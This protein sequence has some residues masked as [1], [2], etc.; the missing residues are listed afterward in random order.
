MSALI[1]HGPADSQG[2]RLSRVLPFVRRHLG[3]DAVVVT[4][5]C[6]GR[7]VCRAFDGDAG[8]FGI[9][10]D[11]AA[12]AE[13]DHPTP[14]AACSASV[15]IALADGR[16]YGTLRCLSAR[17]VVLDDHDATFLSL[18]AEMLA[19][20]LERATTAQRRLADLQQ[21]LMPGAITMA[22]QPIITLATGRCAGV[23]ALARFR[24]VGAT[25]DVVFGQALEAGLAA[26]LELAAV[27]S[28]LAQRPRL[29][30]G[31]YLSVNVGPTAIL[32]PGFGAAIRSSG[33]L[34]GLVL[35]ITEHASVDEYAAL[36]RVLGPLR[37]EGLRLAVDDVGAGYASLRHVLRMRPD[38]IKIDRSLIDGIAGDVAQ[39]S[40]VTSI[41]LL[42]LDMAAEIVA[43]G[44]ER[45][46]D[47]LALA[48]LG[49]DMVQGYLFAAPTVE[50][51]HWD[52]WATRRF[53]PTPDA[54]APMDRQR[55]RTGHP[56]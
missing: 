43:E 27:R 2:N 49:V 31:L 20:Q 19:E 26:E 16:L 41:V 54:G 3:V 18:F 55:D 46:A 23:E 7:D 15:P 45:R 8:A 34:P 17:G 35:E 22:M 38:I 11:G 24:S 56:R 25:P 1:D 5:H 37:D 40:I 33:P 50:R 12:P 53:L 9:V 13:P 42:S 28:A 48:D 39:R 14:G 21:A 36:R 32:A 4:E 29:P 44:V 47:A 6:D 30:D 52:R 10:L 51:A